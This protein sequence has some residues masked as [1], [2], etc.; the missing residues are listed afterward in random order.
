MKTRMVLA[1]AAL[2]IAANSAHAAP[3]MTVAYRFDTTGNTA[4]DGTYGQPTVFS[5][6]NKTSTLQMSVTAWQ[7]NLVTNAITPAYLGA[8]S[9]GLGVTGAGDNNGANGLHQIDNVGGYTDFLLL[10]FNQP[11]TLASIETNSY[12]INGIVDNDAVW[13]DASAFTTSTWNST[14]GLTNYLTVPS[15]WSAVA[16]GGSDVWRTTGATTASTKWLVGAAFGPLFDRDDG[17]KLA[18]VTVAEQVPSVP[19]PATWATMIL[20]LGLA[21]GALRRSRHQT[22]ATATA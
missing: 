8:Y 9:G 3:T 4:L 12:G 11:V 21:G 14:A 6:A 20:G 19:E 10:E 7:S 2:S 15:T 5:T 22:R 16:N 13:Y 18:S 1:A 17:F